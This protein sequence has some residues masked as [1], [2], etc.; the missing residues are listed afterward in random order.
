MGKKYQKLYK[1]WVNNCPNGMDFDVWLDKRRDERKEKMKTAND[2][3]PHPWSEPVPCDG[4]YLCWSKR[5]Y[6]WYGD[7]I[8][9]E[10]Q[11]KSL[12]STYTH[13]MHMPPVPTEV[14]K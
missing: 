9:R 8:K 10:D 13:W 2:Y 12:F 14:T 4:N 1:E 11:Y 7:T 3:T 6:I 5:D